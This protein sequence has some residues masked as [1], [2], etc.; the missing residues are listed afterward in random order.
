[1]AVSKFVVR[2]MTLIVSGA[3][4]FGC[5]SDDG[6]GE[7]AASGSPPSNPGGAQTAAAPVGSVDGLG[8]SMS[9]TPAAA[10]QPDIG[11]EDQ[12]ANALPDVPGDGAGLG[13]AVMDDGSEPELVG[14][15]ADA[16]MPM[17][18]EAVDDGSGAEPELSG[19]DEAAADPPAEDPSQTGD[20]PSDEAMAGADE[21]VDEMATTPDPAEPDDT[22]GGELMSSGDFPEEDVMAGMTDAHNLVRAEVDTDEPLPELS[23]SPE[24]AE[25]A[26]EWADYLAEDCSPR[27]RD[28][29][30]YG[31]NIATF[32][33]APNWP[34]MTPEDAVRGWAEEINCWE[35]GQFM[36]TDSCDMQ[37]TAALNASGCGHYTQLVWRET[38][39]VGCGMSRCSQGQF[40]TEIWVCNYGPAGNW[41]GQFPY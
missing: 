16:T 29:S 19:S 37:C 7:W 40:N 24:L 6:S 22:A 2:G 34:D 1:M 10:T 25:Y 15:G 13:V 12:T 39:E 41:V 26:Q 17:E 30:D 33:A 9:G 28:T 27:H 31:E 36:R 20:A 11:G 23:W 38:T 3:V 32:G 4:S 18:A 5:A 35:Y 14:D 8:Q 21:P